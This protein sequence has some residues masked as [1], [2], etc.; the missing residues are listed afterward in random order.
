VTRA[1]TTS[2]VAPSV[3]PAMSTPLDSSMHHTKNVTPASPTSL[4]SPNSV[5][6]A[7]HP[8][9]HPIQ[10]PRDYMQTRSKSGIFIPKKHF[11]LSAIVSI[12]PI[13]AS[14]RSALKDPNWH[15]AMREEFHALMN[16]RIW[17]LVPCPVGVNIV[18]GKWIFR[19]KFN[20]D[21]SLA[22]YKARWVVRGGGAPSS[23]E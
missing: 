9:W 11:N 20:S 13:P 1:H 21:G 22:R 14:Y 8:F 17:D 4:P 10:A 12:S 15:N 2:P 6:T 18:T 19:H 3:A 7:P 16:Q 5:S 23:M